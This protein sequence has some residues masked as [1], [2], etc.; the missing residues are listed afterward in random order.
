MKNKYLIGAT[1]LSLAILGGSAAL[2]QTT[3]PTPT[4]DN[5]NVPSATVPNDQNT[6]T[7]PQNNAIPRYGMM[8]RFGNYNNSGRGMMNFRAP[9]S[10]SIPNRSG[11][12][13]VGFTAWR[14]FAGAVTMLLVWVLLVLGILTLLQHFKMCRGKCKTEKD[15]TKK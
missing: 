8:G 1:V 4:N 15:E 7:T 2:A 11:Y 13:N 3:S 6:G 14:I 9:S 5:S 12:V 10:K